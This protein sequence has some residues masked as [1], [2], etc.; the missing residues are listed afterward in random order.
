MNN[1]K[2]DKSAVSKL[3]E[4]LIEAPVDGIQNTSLVEHRRDQICDAALELF[5][6]KG[7]ASTT[8]RDICARSGVNQASIYDY[9]A[10]KNDIL[11][12]LLNKLW[13]RSGA[14]NLDELLDEQGDST[15]FEQLVARYLSESWGKKRK[16]TLLAYRTVPHL[17]KADRKAMR[18]R[19][20]MVIQALADKL[21]IR[22]E[23]PEGDY[24]VEVIA[25]LIIYLAGFGPMRDW[26][27]Q[28]LEPEQIVGTVAAGI[29]AMVEHLEAT[30]PTQLSE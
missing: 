9:I 20:E 23:L 19:D 3:P 13:F 8:I 17:Q 25:N 5:L 29:N 10:N 2:T 11:R 16:G 22:T 12:R 26:L 4:E 6:Q 1:K 15:S 21:R 28:D 27:H 14:P 30:S 24:R 18:R 7:F